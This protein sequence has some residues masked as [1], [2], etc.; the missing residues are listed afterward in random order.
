MAP[1]ALGESDVVRAGRPWVAGN[2]IGGL[3]P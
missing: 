1:D 3:G 2:K